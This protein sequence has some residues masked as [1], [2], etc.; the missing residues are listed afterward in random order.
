[1]AIG[2][3][4]I[5]AATLLRRKLVVDE[6]LPFPTGVATGEVIETIFAARTDRDAP[7]AVAGRRRALAAMVVT[8]FRDG[9]PALI[10][11]TTAFGGAVP[12]SR[13]AP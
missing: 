12:A 5:F 7:R 3:V 2:I 6:A 13:S 9:R 10:P 1:M 8:W 11:Q 4:G